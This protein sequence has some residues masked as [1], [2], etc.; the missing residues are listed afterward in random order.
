VTR[1]ASALFAC[2]AL[3]LAAAAPAQAAISFGTPV[4]IPEGGALARDVVAGDFNRDGALDVAIANTNSADVSVLL[5]DGQGLFGLPELYPTGGAP[6]DIA[7]GDFDEDGL[8]DLAVAD[9]NGRVFV[10]PGRADGKFGSAQAVQTTGGANLV[11][12]GDVNGDGNLDLL[13]ADFGPAVGDVSIELGDG[14]GGFAPPLTQNARGAPVQLELAEVNGDG[15]ADVITADG[16]MQ[17]VSVLPGNADGTIGPIR[18]FQIGA[19]T[20][21]LDLAD[22][23]E[24]GNVDIAVGRME[25]ALTVLLGA[26]GGDFPSQA[27]FATPFIQPIGL[28]AAD[29]D[30]D[31]HADLV[32]AQ[33]GI[34]T[35]RGTGTGSFEPAIDD[36]PASGALELVAADVDGDSLLDI[37]SVMGTDL[38]VVPNVSDAGPPPLSP[39]T[40][41]R[42]ANV[43]PV[44]GVVLVKEPGAGRFIRL[45]R[46]DQIPIGS[47]VDSTNGT[48]QLT[49]SAGGRRVQTGQFRGGLFKLG[50]KR[51]RRPV[52]ELTLTAR[53]RCADRSPGP[54]G[55]A[56][57][58]ARSRRLFGNARGRFRSRGRHSTATIRGTRWLVK[59]TC[60]TTL[61]RSLRGTVF[62]R[63]L[64][65]DRKVTLRSGQ[66]YVA[67]AR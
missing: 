2:T 36:P 53:L 1:S 17:S 23:N 60:R 30:G 27:N 44:R 15:R 65:K 39:P 20:S 50:Q 21:G 55:S 64:V 42:T 49:T 54:V 16:G 29:F 6:S 48:V 57:R 37:V 46:S 45:Q 4:R 66:Q 62:V 32:A 18:S 31:D 8:L 56:G 47:V 63:D 34:D 35:L 52:T 7:R 5:G 59:D 51:V 12:V 25:S 11:A 28:V 67:R 61:T 38:I 22:F 14:D 41:A 3:A 33:G 40:L 58:R 10:L 24:D 43:A 13:S 9:A 26:G 19:N